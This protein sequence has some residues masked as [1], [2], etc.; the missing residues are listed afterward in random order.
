[1][2]RPEILTATTRI[3]AAPAEVFPYLIDPSLIVEWIGNWAE[4]KPEPGGVFAL[5]VHGT[6]VRGSYLSVEPPDRVVFTWGARGSEVLPP[7]STTVEIRLT[8]D[9]DETIVELRH[10]DLPVKQ[11][12]PHEAGWASYL[13]ILRYTAASVDAKGAPAPAVIPCRRPD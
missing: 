10:Y 5:D 1:V 3:A 12:A 7:G 13:E 4:L 8:A 9:G 2:N 11:R 6:E